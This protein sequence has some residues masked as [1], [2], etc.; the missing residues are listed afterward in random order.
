[1]LPVI[2]AAAARLAPVAAR[3]IGGGASSIARS[4][5]GSAVR[6]LAS[7][8][9]VSGALSKG[10]SN[11]SSGISKQVG[12][13]VG[14]YVKK[15]PKLQSLE[16]MTK[17]VFGKD[18]STIAEKA[19]NRYIAR[20]IEKATID[21]EEKPEEKRKT[22]FSEKLQDLDKRMASRINSFNKKMENRLSAI[23]LATKTSRSESN[24]NLAKGVSTGIDQLNTTL[25][26]NNS[27][28]NKNL[29]MMNRTLQIMSSSLQNSLNELQQ[30]KEKL[31]EPNSIAVKFGPK[32]EATKT[33]RKMSKSLERLEKTKNYDQLMEIIEKI[34]EKMDLSPS[35]EEGPASSQQREQQQSRQQ[36]MPVQ[37]HNPEEQSLNQI[38][39]QRQ[40]QQRQRNQQPGEMPAVDAMGNATP[41]ASQE[42]TRTP[43]GGPS[44]TP[45]GQ[46]TPMDPNDMRRYLQSVALV[47]SGGQTGATARTSSASGL[48][49]FTQGTWEDV[50]KRMGKNWSPEDRFDPQKSAEA[51]AYLTNLNR[52]QI[53]RATGRQASS[54]D[55]YMGHFLGGGGASK[56]LTGMQRDPNQSAA[57]LAGEAAARA[58]R[59]IFYD[60]SG[61]ERSAQEVY[62]MMKQKLE[63]ADTAVQ[64]NRY[65]RGAVPE[66]IRNINPGGQQPQAQTQPQPQAQTQ[67]QPQAVQQSNPLDAQNSS[68]RVEPIQRQT[69]E[70][71]NNMGTELARTREQATGMNAAA[72]TI[73]N[74][75]TNNNVGGG[76]AMN[77]GPV[78]SVRNEE[79]SLM[80]VQNAIAAQAVS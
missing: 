13:G 20:K 45:A 73:V 80:R 24:N 33:F 58:N 69:G 15:S 23:G 1:M 51:A 9:G 21:K 22:G 30:I 41:G 19:S 46:T 48:F 18:L 39:Q 52:A 60:Q 17:R 12:K 35:S 64:T 68:S 77:Q 78:A 72:P 11:I 34:M 55:L 50:T 43:S 36:Q 49:Q 66:S 57:S 44:A 28:M 10:A 29:A 59:S 56:F 67:P 7:G 3:M 61:R 6:S 54:A 75:T 79:S 37:T 4:L 47:E 42:A 40:P 71:V 76:G 26:N 27:A 62:D 16:S 70:V 32:S 8:E 63:R 5:G 31:Y 38:P 2:A 65:G 74:N 14:E 53:E 25:S